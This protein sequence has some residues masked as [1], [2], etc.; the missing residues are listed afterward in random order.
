MIRR[1]ARSFLLKQGRYLGRCG[2]ATGRN[3]ALKLLVV[4]EEEEEEE[5]AVG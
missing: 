4:V 1:Q 3:F 5:D 2:A